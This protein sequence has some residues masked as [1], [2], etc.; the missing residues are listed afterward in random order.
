MVHG[1]HGYG[2]K[3]SR[4]VVFCPCCC[5]NGAERKRAERHNRFFRVFRTFRI[6]LP[7]LVVRSLHQRYTLMLG[8]LLLSPTIPA[9][10][11]VSGDYDDDEDAPSS[12]SSSHPT[13]DATNKRKSTEPMAPLEKRAK[14]LA[15]DDD[16][17]PLPASFANVTVPKIYVTTSP[18]L[19]PRE[20]K[21]DNV[22]MADRKRSLLVP[23]QLRKK[24]ANIA[25][26]DTSSWTTDRMMRKARKPPPIVST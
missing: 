16:L 23:P 26:E 9:M 5:V 17:P 13:K 4:K 22:E 18:T 14:T 7:H 12:P 15:D 3:D 8:V 10:S 21:T 6:L 2:T 11:L 1:S 19:P 24:Q 25:T 20:T